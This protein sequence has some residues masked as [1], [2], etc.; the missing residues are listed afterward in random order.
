[1]GT[2]GPPSHRRRIQLDQIPICF[3]VSTRRS[4]RLRLRAFRLAYENLLCAVC[5]DYCTPQN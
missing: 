4:L 1:M 3:V 2:G 5:E